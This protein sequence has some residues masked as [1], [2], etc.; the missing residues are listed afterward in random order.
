MLLAAGSSTRFGGLCKK[1]WLRCGHDPLW[2]F[3]TSQ[4]QTLYPDTPIIIVASRDDLPM[5]QKE[6]TV[7]TLVM[8]GS[9][10]QES[11]RNA[12]DHVATPY[13]LT[14]DVARPCLQGDLIAR[15]LSLKNDASCVIPTLKVNDTVLLFKET[16]DRE[17]VELVQTPQL[18]ETSLLRE[19]LKTDQLF[20]DD[21]S[22]IKAMGGI[23]KSVE[24]D[25]LMHKLT[26]IE[27]LAK[28][29]C[30]PPPNF[31]SFTG[32]GFDIHPF[33]E[34][35]PMRLGGVSIDTP[36]GFKA[37]SD[38]DVAIHAL[39]DALVGAAGLGDIGEFF[40]DTD[41]QYKG[42]NSVELLDRCVSLLYAIGYT[43]VHADIT[44]IAQK[45]R[46]LPYKDAIR[47]TLATILKIPP[48]RMN[49]K[50]TTAEKLGFIG[51]EEGVAVMANATLTY[52]DWRNL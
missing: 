15:L 49:V 34:G 2:K 13:V 39:I 8:G 18:S 14:S 4:W 20:T 24:G 17:G 33:E 44:I 40:P 1:H 31:A 41:Q 45:P 11:L 9:T 48:R 23:V 16:I 25:P 5:M 35:K 52:S 26:R 36:Y 47:T 6:G 10:R 21:S 19:A 29:P 43:I 27:D 42:I 51:R 28:L 32:T 38:G 12:L 46:L 37:H 22:A 7:A 30:L 50:A 3:V